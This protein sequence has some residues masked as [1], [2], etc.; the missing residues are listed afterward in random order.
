MHLLRHSLDFISCKDRKAVIPE[1]R[2][3]RP[4]PGMPRRAWPRSRRSKPGPGA[5]GTP[6]SRQPGGANRDL[7][8][9]ASHA[10]PE[11]VRRI[12]TTTN[13]IEALNPKL[14][15]AIRALNPKLRRAIRARGHVPS[16]DAATTLPCLVLNR[17]AADW[18]RPPQE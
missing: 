1:L 12:V 3:I 6:P 13:A 8:H 16:D 4:S 15:R 18:K 10:F 17:A 9:P 7:R 2:A 14:R 11:A 5:P